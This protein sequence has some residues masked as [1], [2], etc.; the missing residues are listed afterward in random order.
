MASDTQ[1]HSTQTNMKKHLPKNE[2]ARTQ[3]V[4][5]NPK[6]SMAGKAETRCNLF[7]WYQMLS[8]F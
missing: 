4:K 3:T 2:K 1:K 6:I 7:V 8:T 5:L